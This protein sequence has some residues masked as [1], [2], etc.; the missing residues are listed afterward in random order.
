MTE[1]KKKEEVC[2]FKCGEP[3]SS[4]Y[5]VFSFIRDGKLQR[6]HERC[7]RLDKQGKKSTKFSVR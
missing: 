1:K 6:S 3:L 5:R 4:D 7:H 2:F